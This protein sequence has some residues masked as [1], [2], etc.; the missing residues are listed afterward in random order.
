MTKIRGADNDF[1]R[2]SGTG[3]G[4]VLYIANQALRASG[5]KGIRH[6]RASHRDP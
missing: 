4:G 2:P 1:N 5:T 3:T 6:R